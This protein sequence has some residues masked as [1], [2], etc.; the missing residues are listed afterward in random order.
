VDYDF[1]TNLYQQP[2]ASFS[3][4]H[5]AIGRWFTEELG[6]SGDK[7]DVLL[8]E[9]DTLLAAGAEA[10]KFDMQGH[11]FRLCIHRGEVLIAAL[12]LGDDEPWSEAGCEADED[13]MVDDLL[14][15]G[16]VYDQELY[17]E[18]GLLDFYTALSSW[19]AFVA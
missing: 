16:R 13:A 2:E 18:C 19:R 1:R 8:Q 11:T 12:A 4:G 5:E 7:I 3:M 17:A 14:E 15:N 6:A 10:E 9:L